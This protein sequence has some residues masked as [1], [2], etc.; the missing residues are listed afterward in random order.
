MV[1]SKGG[2]FI[3]DL[4]RPFMPSKGYRMPNL[5]RGISDLRLVD[6]IAYSYEKKKKRL[7]QKDFHYLVLELKKLSRKHDQ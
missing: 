3:P 2:R 5:Q 7:L 4:G 6:I 1:S